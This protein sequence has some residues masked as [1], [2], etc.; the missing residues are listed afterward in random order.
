MVSLFP[1]TVEAVGQAI[2]V[3]FI[4]DHKPNDFTFNVR[5]QAE[6]LG[7]GKEHLIMEEEKATLPSGTYKLLTE[8]DRQG[9]P[10]E[11]IYQIV[12]NRTKGVI[13]EFPPSHVA[14]N[15]VFLEGGQR[16][17]VLVHR[18]LRPYNAIFYKFGGTDV[19]HFFARPYPRYEFGIGEYN[20]TDQFSSTQIVLAF[21][22]MR[23]AELQPETASHI[24]ERGAASIIPEFIEN[25]P[26]KDPVMVLGA[27][28]IAK[29]L[30]H[31]FVA[32]R[33][34]QGNDYRGEYSVSFLVR[35]QDGKLS[36]RLLRISEEELT[37]EF[38][39]RILWMELHNAHR[40]RESDGY[41]GKTFEE[42]L[43]EA[44]LSVLRW[45]KVSQ[46]ST[47]FLL[48]RV[49]A[50]EREAQH[51]SYD[52]ETEVYGEKKILRSVLEEAI[53]H[54]LNA[55]HRERLNYERYTEK[56]LR[57]AGIEPKTIPTRLQLLTEWEEYAKERLRALRASA[58]KSNDER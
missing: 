34:S 18:A 53:D 35:L 52:G 26:T 1:F 48:E 37:E 10:Q 13:T 23:A 17:R 14:V 19:A 2:P 42:V 16:L 33:E 45:P 15:H 36:E 55:I 29:N 21:L 30:A 44:R 11:V 5:L 43:K 58:R 3:D 4:H 54:L 8:H 25:I 47:K 20:G 46:R 31:T 51:K 7:T 27:R 28:E 6:N 38:A 50:L 22:G 40:P 39:R 57:K 32:E 49:E 56:M 41:A 24:K 12:N 9:F